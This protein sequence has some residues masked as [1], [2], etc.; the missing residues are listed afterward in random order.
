MTLGERSGRRPNERVDVD[1]ARGSARLLLDPTVGPYV[2]TKLLASVGIWIYNVVAAVVVFD[3][4]GSAFLVG[5]VSV[6]QFTPQVLLAPWAGA[7]ADRRSRRAQVMLGRTTSAVGAGALTAWLAAGGGNPSG[8]WP[9]VAAALLVGV[10]FAISTPAMQ[11]LVP[12]LVQ[13]RELPSMVTL[14]TTPF[15]LARAAGPA[16]GALILATAGPAAAFGVAAASQFL[17]AA[18]VGV[19]RLRQVEERPSA[20]TSVWAGIRHVRADPVLMLLLAAVVGIG[21]GVDPVITLTPALAAELGSGANLVA[22]MASA[23]GLGA[24]TT[25]LVLGWI[26]KRTRETAIGPF[27]LT[28]L[29]LSL[30][31]LAASTTAQLALATL[32]IG[33]VGMMLGITSFTTQIQQ[34]L[35]E[36]LRGRVMGLWAVCFV[37]SRPL[38]AVLNGTLADTLSTQAALLILAAILISIVFLTR[39]RAPSPAP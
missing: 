18:V 34:R 30:V 19:I 31:V 28:L 20:D 36:Q 7:L 26:R 10:G 15:T 35:P 29:A 14:D 16:L 11:A 3:A 22:L 9:V 17:L 12:A 27:G 25:P 13:P 6:A 1:A 21:L 37:G 33:G 38:A 24:A 5:A 4:T 32:Y 2:G 8:P 23:F 39:P